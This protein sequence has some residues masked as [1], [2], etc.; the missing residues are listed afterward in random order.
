MTLR[1]SGFG[2]WLAWFGLSALGWAGLV[3]AVLALVLVLVQDP[4][5]EP[6]VLVRKEEE[7]M[8]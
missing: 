3:Q 1:I 8:R 6:R 7:E 4:K 5:P 2:P